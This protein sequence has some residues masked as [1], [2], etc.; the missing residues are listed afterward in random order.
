MQDGKHANPFTGKAKLL[1]I[2]SIVLTIAVSY[3][4]FSYL[5]NSSEQNV[6][7]SIFEQQR[8]NQL[9]DTEALSRDVGTDL[10]LVV[11]NLRPSEFHIHSARRSI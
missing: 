6:R 2:I 8:Q 5:E 7:N 1:A 4:I 11:D 10:S 3:G 9:K